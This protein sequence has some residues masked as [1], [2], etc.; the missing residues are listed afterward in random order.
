MPL[1]G[2]QPSVR[3]LCHPPP[4]CSERDHRYDPYLNSQECL[5]NQAASF[6]LKYRW[7]EVEAKTRKFIFLHFLDSHCKGC[8]CEQTSTRF[9]LRAY[10]DTGRLT[11]SATEMLQLLT[12]GV[13][14]KLSLTSDVWFSNGDDKK[15]SNTVC[16]SDIENAIVETARDAGI[17]HKKWHN[18]DSAWFGLLWLIDS[19]F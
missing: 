11:S 16:R 6:L 7:F 4:A 13:L 15:A 2:A 1:E 5:F 17:E 12:S 8:W 19:F 9:Q 10:L 18:T 3:C 14:S